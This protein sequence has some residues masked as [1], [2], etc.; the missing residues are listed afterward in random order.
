MILGGRIHVLAGCDRDGF[1]KSLFHRVEVFH[2]HPEGH[3]NVVE[4]F[5]HLNLEVT[6]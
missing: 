5:T 4:G 2:D 6:S 1:T 3:P